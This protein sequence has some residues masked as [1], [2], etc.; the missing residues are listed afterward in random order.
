MNLH[1]GFVV[2]G[3]SFYLQ[4]WCMKMKGPVFVAMWT[5]IC[6][7]LTT[8]CTS[9]ILGENVQ[10]RSIIGGVLLVGGLYSMLWGKSIELKIP[11]RSDENAS[12]GIQLQDER[13]TQEAPQEEE[14]TSAPTAEQV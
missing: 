11:P 13:I 5:P 6:F 2:S 7:V 14:K 9:F 4:I 12:N 3:V 10:L 1:Q 8:F